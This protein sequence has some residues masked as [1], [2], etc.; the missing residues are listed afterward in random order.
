MADLEDQASE[1]ASPQKETESE[2]DVVMKFV[3][4]ISPFAKAYDLEDLRLYAIE[5]PCFTTDGTKFADVVLEVAPEGHVVTDNRDNPTFV[6]EFKKDKVDYHSAVY[7]TLRY[8][9]TLK[10]QLYR[11]HVEGFVVAPDFSD[12][13]KS[14]AMEKGINLC[15]Y[16]HVGNRVLRV[17]GGP[18][19]TERVVRRTRNEP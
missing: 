15:S 2:H 4:D 13:E 6:L 10:K 9:E 3:S 14:F 8:V 19:K 18:S 17:I 16:D 11:E 7:Q 12:F 1:S 5:L